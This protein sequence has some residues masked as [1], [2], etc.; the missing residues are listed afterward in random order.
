MVTLREG[1]LMYIYVV[2]NNVS[3]K[4]IRKLYSVSVINILKFFKVKVIS[5]FLEGKINIR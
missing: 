5:S 4:V 2:V 3:T 1:E